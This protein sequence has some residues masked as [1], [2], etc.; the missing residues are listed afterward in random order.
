MN[1][2]NIS[3]NISLFGNK[4]K[5]GASD[6][7]STAFEHANNFGSEVGNSRLVKNVAVSREFWYFLFVALSIINIIL[8]AIVLSKSEYTDTIMWVLFTFG[9]MALTAA[10]YVWEFDKGSKL[11]YLMSGFNVFTLYATFIYVQ[12][13]KGFSNDELIEVGYH[14]LQIIL[15]VILFY[16]ISRMLKYN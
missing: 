11:L 15:I 4:L 12:A 10:L 2:K 6:I 1:T 16:A 9:A 14:F 7:A 8:V 5:S 3:D 13:K